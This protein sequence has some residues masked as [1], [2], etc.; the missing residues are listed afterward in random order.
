MFKKP[1]FWTKT[2]RPSVWDMLLLCW[3][4]PQILKILHSVKEGTGLFHFQKCIFF[5]LFPS[6]TPPSHNMDHDSRLLLSSI[7]I[8]SDLPAAHRVWLHLN[9]TWHGFHMTHM[10]L[11]SPAYCEHRAQH[12]LGSTLYSE[13]IFW[14]SNKAVL[15]Q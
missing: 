13:P 11:Q 5:N 10:V 14:H 6:P 8:V 12:P 1:G 7:S 9:G 15:S 3:T 4:F 2:I